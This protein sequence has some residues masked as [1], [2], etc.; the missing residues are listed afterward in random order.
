M[1]FPAFQ[2]VPEVVRVSPDYTCDG[3]LSLELSHRP[4]P[5]VT[6]IVSPN[7]RY[8][9]SV[10]RDAVREEQ[11]LFQCTLLDWGALEVVN[12]ALESANFGKE[13]P[14]VGC[15]VSIG[16]TLPYCNPAW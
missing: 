14:G 15:R 2:G 12:R 10:K 8:A 4:S 16:E 11:N 7:T 6:Q 1:C 13:N 3:C 9:I 5:T